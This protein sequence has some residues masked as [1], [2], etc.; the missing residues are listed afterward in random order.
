MVIPAFVASQANHVG[1]TIGGVKTQYH[2]EN[3]H[4]RLGYALK[5]KTFG[6]NSQIISFFFFESAPQHGLDSLGRSK[7]GGGRETQCELDG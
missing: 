6:K 3:K 5:K 7:D 2:E 4:G 1:F